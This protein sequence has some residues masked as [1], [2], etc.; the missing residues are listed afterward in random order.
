[1]IA[2]WTDFKIKAYENSGRSRQERPGREA[3]ASE[4][5]VAVFS[6]GSSDGKCESETPTYGNTERRGGETDENQQ[7]AGN[8]KR[9]TRETAEGWR[10]QDT[11]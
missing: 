11:D 9:K 7:T 8:M 10:Q 5:A 6:P 4:S 1:M 3:T 2:I